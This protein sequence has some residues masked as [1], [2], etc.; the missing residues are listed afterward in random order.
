MDSEVVARFRN[1]F[2]GYDGAH[3]R[4]ELL[5]ESESGKMEGKAATFRNPPTDKEWNEHL[6]GSRIGM[7]VIPLCRDNTLRFAAIDIDDKKIDLVKLEESCAKLPVV[8]CR[9]KSGGAHVYLFLKEPA[10]ARSIVPVLNRWAAHLGYGGCEV[11][12]KQVTRASERDVGNW[13]NLPYFS[14]DKTE[15]YAIKDGKPITL[16][17]FLDYAESKATIFKQPE[18]EAPAQLDNSEEALF[19]EGPPCLQHLYGVGGFPDGTRND[20][21]YNVAVYLRKRF[22]DNWETALQEYNLKMCKPPLS[23]SEITDVAKSVKKKA[24]TYR[25]Q[26]SPIKAH[27]DRRCCLSRK[28]GV[29][30]TGGVSATVDITSITKYDGDP[31]YWVV[32]MG[33]NRMEIST[34]DLFNQGAFIKHCMN[35]INRCPPM[36]PPARW[37]QFLDVLI[38]SAP[39]IPAPED[40]SKIGQ[41]Y[42]MLDGYCFGRMQAKH[43]D[44]L[45]QGKPWQ[46]GERVYFRSAALFEYLRI[47]RFNYVS[48]HW[49]WNRLKD[50]GA[51]PEQKWVR[52]KNI[53]V[54]SLPI[55]KTPEL[56][57]LRE[58]ADLE[59]DAK[60]ALVNSMR[61]DDP[62]P[63]SDNEPHIP[64]DPEKDPAF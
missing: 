25:C 55:P 53:N 30:E 13:I 46:D 5:H 21:L 34:D 44:E 50:G 6:E 37:H 16:L 9:S 8:I 51:V 63:Q 41:L 15:R 18:K 29:G 33:G 38:K 59:Q 10:P 36:M 62:A 35:L 19:Y 56:M 20:G 17:E 58:L 48:E 7:G 43:P 14:G 11:F 52:G 54:W 32:E 26:Q 4:F 40:A 64:A 22:P 47:K 2:I 45:L 61:D 49:V 23:I 28:H 60:D 31:V 39:T 42:I 12:P 27:C 1:L 57:A 24:Y 3:G